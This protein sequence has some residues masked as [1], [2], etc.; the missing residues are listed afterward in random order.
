MQ[1]TLFGMV[2]RMIAD[3]RLPA[4]YW[5]YALDT[6]IW[7]KNRSATRALKGG[8]TPHEVFWGTKPDLGIA[9]VFGS[10]AYV[11]VPADLR[12]KLDARCIPCLFLGYAHKYKAWRFLDLKTGKEHVSAQARFNERTNDARRRR[13]R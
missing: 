13:H 5:D 2:R 8:I 7:L 9:R 12:K 3:A 1:G 11:H 6:A 10:P 4:S